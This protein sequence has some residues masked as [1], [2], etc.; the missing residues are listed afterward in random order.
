MTVL[1]TYCLEEFDD[2]NLLLILLQ[3]YY[4]SILKLLGGPVMVPCWSRDGRGGVSLPPAP[5]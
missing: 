5:P 1:S 3:T 2:V 4:N